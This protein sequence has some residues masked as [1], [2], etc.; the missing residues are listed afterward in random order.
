MTSSYLFSVDGGWGA[1]YPVG[2]CSTTCGPGTVAA[3]RRCDT[4]SPQYGGE[5]CTGEN[6]T[7]I[8]CDM[9]PCPGM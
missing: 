4:P 8:S 5:N 7:F 2:I 1:Y 6:S 9:E 3:E